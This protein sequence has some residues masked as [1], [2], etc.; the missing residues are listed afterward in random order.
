MCSLLKVFYKLFRVAVFEMKAQYKH[1]CK[2]VIFL[3]A[4]KINFLWLYISKMYSH[5]K[6][7]RLLDSLQTWFH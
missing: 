2:F 5:N 6:T 4:R 7:S 1:L 3:E